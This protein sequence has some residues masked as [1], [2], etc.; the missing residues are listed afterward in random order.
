MTED[1]HK[2]AIIGLGYVGLPLL[3]Q[4]SK[5]FDCLGLDVDRIRIDELSR[6]LR[7]TI[8]RNVP[9]NT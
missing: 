4:L 9:L 1:K 2:V 7:L 6:F 5:K 8:F 3:C